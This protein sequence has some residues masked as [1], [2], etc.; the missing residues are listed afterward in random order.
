MNAHPDAALKPK[1]QALLCEVQLCREQAALASMPFVP[2]LAATVQFVSALPL[3]AA[4]AVVTV[5]ES[6]PQFSRVEP[7][8]AEIAAPVAVLLAAVQLVNVDAVPV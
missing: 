1:V 7:S 5:F 3:P 8:P 4:M 2:V 6:A